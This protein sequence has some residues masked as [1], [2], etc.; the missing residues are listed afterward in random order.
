MV[1]GAFLTFML[2]CGH[3]SVLLPASLI[4]RHMVSSQQLEDS[5]VAHLQGLQLVDVIST[6]ATPNSRN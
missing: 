6:A 5:Q 1:L 2:G 4:I 3:K